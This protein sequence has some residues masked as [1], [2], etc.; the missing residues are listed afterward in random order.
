MTMSDFTIPPDKLP[1]GMM[2]PAPPFGGQAA[3]SL[4]QV[5]ISKINYA[6]HIR[7]ALESLPCL[8][9]E[10]VEMYV[11]EVQGQ[12]PAVKLSLVIRGLDLGLEGGGAVGQSGSDE[13]QG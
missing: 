2:P 11:A 8:K 6:G 4:E 10:V 13:G 12:C 3:S 9:V 1:K 5:D 7:R